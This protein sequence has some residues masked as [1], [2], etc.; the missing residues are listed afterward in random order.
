MAE[1]TVFIPQTI[2]YI[3]TQTYV[4]IILVL[5]ILCLS[6]VID[7]MRKYK[8]PDCICNKKS[9]NSYSTS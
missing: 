5:I 8:C 6:A 1:K 7:N 9:I 3:S 2:T 4:I